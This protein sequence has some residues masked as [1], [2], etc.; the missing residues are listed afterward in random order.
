[1]LLGRRLLKTGVRN[2]ILGVICA[3]IGVPLIEIM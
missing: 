3:I 2:A 1:M